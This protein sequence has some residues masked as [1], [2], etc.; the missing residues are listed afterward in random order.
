MRKL[1]I[2]MLCILAV[3]GSGIAWCNFAYPSYSYRYRMT[4][5]VMV[6][7]VLHSASS[8]VEIK[9]QTQPQFG[10][11]LPIV[12]GTRGEATFVDLGG[13]RN[14][15]ALLASGSDGDNVDYPIQIVP[16]LFNIHGNLPKLESLRGRR[17]I[18]EQYLPT[19]ATFDLRDTTI[20]R[21]VSPG[22]F[23]NVFG[24]NVRFKRA[25]IEMT[26]EPVTLGIDEKFV[27]WNGPFPWLKPMSNGI[28]LDTRKIGFRWQKEM[29]QRSF[30]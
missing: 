6:D 28:Y 30:Y 1:G 26:T 11:A 7:G 23:E 13:A 9:L 19:L 3:I 5:E 29:L 27:W 18:P 14:V 8:V 10:S 4:V 16:R 25:W 17:D 22:E 2:I 15:V 12:P 24:P 20:A 21:V